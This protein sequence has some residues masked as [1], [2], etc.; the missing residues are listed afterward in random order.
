MYHDCYTDTRHRSPGASAAHDPS[1][2]RQ[3]ARRLQHLHGAGWSDL[4]MHHDDVLSANNPALPSIRSPPLEHDWVRNWGIP[5]NKLSK[6][7]VSSTGV[8]VL[9]YSS[10]YRVTRSAAPPD[11]YVAG[12][13]AFE[14][15]QRRSAGFH[16]PDIVESLKCTAVLMSVFCIY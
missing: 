4:R 9:Q 7:I 10:S 8:V 16:R 14:P 5:C 11:R 3:L 1:W 2:L 6:V 12:R 15:L 13:A